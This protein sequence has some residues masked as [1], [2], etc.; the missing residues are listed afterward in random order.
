MNRLVSPVVAAVVV[1]LGAALAGCGK[2]GDDVDIAGQSIRYEISYSAYPPSGLLRRAISLS[3]S[4]NDGQQDQRDVP[5]PWNT[6]VDTAR[7]GFVPSITAQF[8]GYG[9]ITCRILAGDKVIQLNTSP[10]GTYPAVECEA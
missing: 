4:T 1:I 5:L 7:A 2:P 3:Y 8:S 6:V 10:E 9:S